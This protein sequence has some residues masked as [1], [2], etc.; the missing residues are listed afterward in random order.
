MTESMTYADNFWLC[1]DDPANLMVIA[2][3]MEFEELI[4]F[5]RLTW[6]VEQRLTSFPR[7]RKKVVKTSYGV[8]AP[9]WEFDKHFDIRSHIHRIALPGAGD[10][11]ELQNMV[12]DFMATPLDYEKPLWQVHLIENYGEGCVILFRIHHC[13]ADGIALI[14][15]LLSTA[16]TDPDAPWPEKVTPVKKDPPTS[17]FPWGLGSVVKSVKRTRGATLRV[18]EKLLKNSGKWFPTRTNW[19]SSRR[20]VLN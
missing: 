18:G 12:G 6:T 14:H 7:F 4:D 3:F 13:I 9:T 1:M 20:T 15:T 11:T 2:A 16:D 5:K 17:L 8:G 10:K 19:W